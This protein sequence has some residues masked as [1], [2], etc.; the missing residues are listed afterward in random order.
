MLLVNVG[1]DGDMYGVSVP[2]HVIAHA[3]YARIPLVVTGTGSVM[4]AG[5]S[6]MVVEIS[7]LTLRTQAP[8]FRL[9]TGNLDFSVQR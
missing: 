8:S 4:L 5:T 1:S 3:R 6:G 9:E 2:S 7:P